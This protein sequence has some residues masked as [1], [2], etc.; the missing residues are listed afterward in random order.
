M[1]ITQSAILSKGV[2]TTMGFKPADDLQQISNT[3]GLVHS[4]E[5]GITVAGYSA[6]KAERNAVVGTFALHMYS[7]VMSAA[8]SKKMVFSTAVMPEKAK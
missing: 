3:G 2:T 7:I 8:G 5:K 4:I 6:K 1:I